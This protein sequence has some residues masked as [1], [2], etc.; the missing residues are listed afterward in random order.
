MFSKNW[1]G[2][3]SY[4]CRLLCLFPAYLVKALDAHRGGLRFGSHSIA[5]ALAIIG[6]V[7][8]QA[9]LAD[10]IPPTGISTFIQTNGPNGA[11]G[12]ADWY[13]ATTVQNGAETY[14]YFEIFVP[15]DWPTD[16][17]IHIDLYSPEINCEAATTGA[18]D[19]VGDVNNQ[20]VN[21]P[22]ITDC[23][24]LGGATDQR[25]LDHAD[26]TRFELY[27]RGTT[28]DYL[29]AMP[30]PGA[31]GSIAS[32]IYDPV[33]TQPE[34]WVRFHTL[35]APVLPGTYVFR[36]DV[37]GDDVNDDFPQD[38]D[39]NA[40]RLRVGWDDDNDINTPPV[41]NPDGNP[42]TNDELFVGV[43]NSTFQHNDNDPNNQCLTL[44]ELIP[45][46]QPD[47]EFDNY[48]IDNNGRVRYYKPSEASLFDPLA[49]LNGTV[50]SVSGNAAWLNGASQPHPDPGTGDN[51]PNPES[52][53]WRA[54]TCVT[55][56]NQY[57]QEAQAAV[58]AFYE[59]PPLPV[60]SLTKDD[61]R[62]DIATGDILTY[63][64]TFANTSDATYHAGAALN[65]TITDPVPAGTQFV[66][67]TIDP[68]YNGAGSSCSESGGVVTYTLSP[69]AVYA[70]DSG[71]VTMT[72]QVTADP[73]SIV[74]NT[75]TLTYEDFFAHPYTT[76]AT[77]IDGPINRIE[78]TVY[79]DVNDNT[80]L[81]PGEPG[82]PN[83]SVRIYQDDGDN[84]FDSGTDTLLKTLT[85]D[86]NGNYR[87]E[88]LLTGR[89]FVASVV[90]SY[91]VGATLT[92]DNEETA[93]FPDTGNRDTGND[94]GFSLPLEVTKTSDATGPLSQGDEITY[95][96]TVTNT[97][98]VAQTGITVDDS[99]PTGTSYVAAS[100]VA[101][102]SSVSASSLDYF[103]NFDG[104]YSG[105][106]GADSWT[107][108]WIEE[109]SLGN[110]D[111]RI[112]NN[113]NNCLS[114]NGELCLRVDADEPGEYIYR[115][116]DLT[117]C[118]SATLSYE[119]TNNLESGDEV[120]IQ[121]ADASATPCDAEDTAN[122]AYN[123]I[124][125]YTNTTSDTNP[126][127]FQLE[128]FFP[129]NVLPDTVRVAFYV[130]DNAG[131]D[132]NRIFFDDLGIA[133]NCAT[134]NGQTL[135]NDTADAT[136]GDLDSG[137]PSTLV[138]SNDNFVLEPSGN[139]GD[140]LT[141]TFKVQVDDPLAP[142]ITEIRNTVLASSDQAG[143][144]RDS[145]G[146]PLVTPANVGDRVWID[147]DGDGGYD[148]G[149][150]GLNGVTMTLYH[151]G[152]DAVAE[153][154]D[155]ISLG[156]TTT[157]ANGRYLFTEVAPGDYYV[158]LNAADLP[159]GLTETSGTTNPGSA[160]TLA[161][162]V[163]Y[164]DA[165]FGYVNDSASTALI[166]DLV[167]SD[168][169]QDGVR[170]AGEPG[171]EGV[172]LEL[173]R[174]SDDQTIA[175]TT[176]A[177][178]GG[179]LFAG[180]NPDTYRVRVTDTGGVLN[181]FTLTTGVN[182]AVE[183]TVAAGET[184]LNA[185]FGFASGTTYT[186]SDRVWYD[187]S[188]DGTQG[189]SEAG[190]EGVTVNLLDN[191]GT[192][193]ATTTTDA[194]G[195]FVFSGVASGNYTLEIADGN[196]VLNSYSG[197]TTDA[198]AGSRAI[199]VPGADVLGVNF[200]YVE[201][202]AIG[203]T[204][205]SDDNNDGA[206][207]PG[208]LGIAGVTLDL[209]RTSDSQT[210]ATTTTAADGSYLFTGID[211][212]TYQ[213]QVTDTSLVLN[214]FTPS[215]GN[216][217][218]VNVTIA[219]NE[220]F[221]DADFGY[222]TTGLAT[223][224][225]LVWGDVNR[226]LNSATESGFA[227][228]TVA[229]VNASDEVVAETVTDA[230]GDFS[231][232]GVADGTYTIE[233]TDE[234]GVLID[235]FDTC[236]VN[237]S[238]P[239]CTQNPQDTR[240]VTVS[241]GTANPDPVEIGYDLEEPT[242]AVISRFGVHLDAAQQPVI[243]WQSASEVGTLGFYLER[244]QPL[245][246]GFVR[247]NQQLLPGGLSAAQGSNY[248]FV[249][250]SAEASKTYTYRLTELQASGRLRIHKPHQ[251]T[252][253]KASKHA[254]F[255]AA[256]QA[257]RASAQFSRTARR[258][259]VEHRRQTRTRREASPSPVGTV[260]IGVREDGLY[261]LSSSELATHL[262]RP[263]A[264]VERWIRRGRLKLHNL[265]RAVAW[266][267]ADDNTGLYF[268][269]QGAKHPHIL[270]NV[271]WLKNGRGKRM[272]TVDGGDPTP[273]A[274]GSY[275]TTARWEEDILALPVLVDD[276]AADYWFWDY[277]MGGHT[278]HGSKTFPVTVEAMAETSASAVLR[279]Q[280]KGASDT[281][282][283]QGHHVE[284][285]LNGTLLGEARWDGRAEHML[286]VEVEPGLLLDGLNEVELT[287]LQETPDASQS[288]V[289]VDSLEL[290]YE[291]YY[292]A[293]GDSLEVRGD[294]NPVV[295]VEGFED[296]N[297]WVLELRKSQQPRWL[298]GT[299][300]DMATDTYRVSFEPAS[301]TTSY[302]AVSAA[303]IKQP[304]WLQGDT[305]SNWRRRNHRV[306]YLV[307]TPKAFVSGA[308]AL[309]NYR[310]SANGYRTEVVLLEDI[311]DEFSFGLSDP[312]AIDAFLVHAYRH[313]RRPPEF[314]V[315]LGDGTYDHRN[316]LGEGDNWMPP[317]LETTPDGLFAG[318]GAYADVNGDGVPEYALGRI[319]VDSVEALDTY[320]RKLMAHEGSVSKSQDEVLLLADNADAGGN[321]P[322]DIVALAERIS[323]T[324][325][326]SMLSL[327]TQPVPEARAE[328]F[329]HWQRGVGL[330]NYLGHGGLDR[331]AEEG[332]LTTEDVATLNS[333]ERLPIVSALSCVINRYAVPGYDSLGEALVLAQTGGAIA[334]WGPTG[335]SRN[336]EAVRLNEALFEA[337][338]EAEHA[339]LGEAVMGAL[340]RYG[341]ISRMPYMLRIYTLLGDPALTLP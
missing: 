260:K 323:P 34:Q 66:A 266:R 336:A 299:R 189:G 97:S 12:L 326:L 41:D 17:P 276:P 236:V 55:P 209:V 156:T 50:G 155:D 108:S 252:V 164:L 228:V 69:S 220:S 7:G 254:R 85:T 49:N 82:Q 18:V 270:D 77:D 297:P 109:D 25:F 106:Q 268:Y 95:T 272:A 19:E 161:S 248:R 20:E 207:G 275:H 75:A 39:Q 330:V 113:N 226:D 141:V 206:Q 245:G 315:L 89:F 286:E 269:G 31:A 107:E 16:K 103:H 47:I 283:V 22:A 177:A 54:V 163:D 64:L 306:D 341:R 150:P 166:G 170:D 288:T 165:D 331:L 208:E 253:A 235:Y 14:H 74:T 137:T 135:D 83:V 91:P 284:I 292:R 325:P 213:V 168:F 262:G 224:T 101:D 65:V 100:T 290:D 72:V 182:P 98:G 334:T 33:D 8:S 265:G 112:V 307:L 204:V 324:V 295:S 240:T 81:D 219:A 301:P 328:L 142:G 210:I 73:V 68:P 148:I 314:V 21:N 122:C 303:G 188:S 289:L 128:T 329:E 105:S 28:T 37:V 205:F 296:P 198:T 10:E 218:T 310:A 201:S 87:F 234:A 281:A 178:D 185:D 110:N 30:E 259:L 11:I 88:T 239:I 61:G 96:I 172:T 126:E 227:G 149:E 293:Q 44:Y 241:G 133:A 221:L 62:L 285:A 298:N 199:Q 257:T 71:S 15:D 335:L 340:S 173:V 332:W 32:T 319:P 187:A 84:L 246:G 45:Q 94:F 80:V 263:V 145:I 192:I 90:G 183:V 338:Y 251:V 231:F 51:F 247:L 67:C 267:A 132:G 321:F 305:P 139:A 23:A 70:G 318:D 1:V 180:V 230:N 52:G 197:T 333:P 217:G 26:D 174:T 193:V 53:I 58:S 304:A 191:G 46:G 255:M 111:I 175:T 309:A 222:Q 312:R 63:T 249:D 115:E 244:Q 327:D 232:T 76:T 184:F 162:G 322:A 60:M 124:K 3:G 123:L 287:A 261:Y 271:Y 9:L 280:L 181:G 258:S 195:D 302:F 117:G 158:S 179:Y 125:E 159:T 131:G 102:N 233:V 127:S 291:R 138:T 146:D 243:A 2:A 320:L 59:A 214:G 157:D 339:T 311:Y 308:R 337:L 78:G 167:W 225:G 242:H 134:F 216:T 86:A 4:L 38:N 57:I 140:T 211:P 114:G 250:P 274:S 196:G 24:S 144:A 27:D 300:V 121:V 212:G 43:V 282:G 147:V 237:G 316:L 215:T 5:S 294:G 186:I 279:V 200:G 129:G 143:P 92:T 194:S 35:A 120:Q 6:L 256:Q 278:Q 154:G 152:P 118:Q 42:G 277:L 36:T 119:F 104:G 151:V 317:V 48:D 160:F 169:D 79:N 136:N 223:L 29:N 56:D 229:L 203:D 40:W 171:I 202:G 99:L 176:T 273:V 93:N 264:T 238:E 153:T 116:A 190:I 313:W 13:S 130:D